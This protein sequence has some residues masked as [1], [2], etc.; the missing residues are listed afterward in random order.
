MI[1]ITIES[2]GRVEVLQ[3]ASTIQNEAVVLVDLGDGFRDRFVTWR[4]GYKQQSTCRL[5][6]RRL[7][8]TTANLNVWYTEDGRT[9]CS[10]D[11]PQHEPTSLAGVRKYQAWSGTYHSSR[12]NAERDFERRAG[13]VSTDSATSR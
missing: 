13:Y 1:A 5:C 8:R 10:A 3:F 9:W 2:V 4:I 12:L 11:G 7:E 6:G